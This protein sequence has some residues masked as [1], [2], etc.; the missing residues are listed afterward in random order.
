[1][2]FTYTNTFP[3]YET[4]PNEV[5]EIEITNRKNKPFTADEINLIK[6]QTTRMLDLFLFSYV[7]QADEADAELFEETINHL[8]TSIITSLCINLTV[9]KNARS[10]PPV[11]LSR[12]T[13]KTLDFG[14]MMDIL[15]I[16]VDEEAAR[17]YMLPLSRLSITINLLR[18]AENN[19]KIRLKGKTILKPQGGEIQPRPRDEPSKIDFTKCSKVLNP[20]RQSAVKLPQNAVSM[21]QLNKYEFVLLYYIINRAQDV[22]RLNEARN[23]AD[24]V[25]NIDESFTLSSVAKSLKLAENGQIRHEIEKAFFSLSGKQLAFYVDKQYRIYPVFS[26]LIIDEKQKIYKLND[27]ILRDRD[28]L[29]ELILFRKHYDENQGYYDTARLTRFKDFRDMFKYKGDLPFLVACVELLNE[30]PIIEKRT[31]NNYFT[32]S[33]FRTKLLLDDTAQSDR[34]IKQNLRRAF[35]FLGWKFIAKKDKFVVERYADDGDET[36]QISE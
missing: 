27:E 5:Y 14:R 35:G 32:V 10:Y 1:M 16:G 29:G 8:R 11:H 25:F 23:T 34:Y 33:N 9:P 22:F 13:L 3:I 21:W 24:G 20:L 19:Q 17:R 26:K 2:K 15:N 30:I 7:F 12:E 6:L 28:L 36:A 4:E 31:T 18:Y